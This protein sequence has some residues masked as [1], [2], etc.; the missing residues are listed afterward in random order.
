MHVR[1]ITEPT[2]KSICLVRTIIACTDETIRIID[3]STMISLILLA[4]RKAPYG[5]DMSNAATTTM[6][7]RYASRVRVGVHSLSERVLRRTLAS[8]CPPVLTFLVSPF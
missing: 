3:E 5:I 1:P 7:A 8:D 6:A 4:L 2:D